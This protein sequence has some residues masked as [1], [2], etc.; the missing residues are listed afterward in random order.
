MCHAYKPDIVNDSRVQYLT[1]VESFTYIYKFS[2]V[3]GG[4]YRHKWMNVAVPEILRFNGILVRDSVIGG[5]K[6]A[7][8]K[9]WNPN[10]PIYNP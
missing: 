4:S 9:R 7:L 1:T 10:S 2:T 5:S 6:G 3:I 8:H